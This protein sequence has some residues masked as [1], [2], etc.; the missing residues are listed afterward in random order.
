M[1][2]R[3]YNYHYVTNTKSRFAVIWNERLKIL[4]SFLIFC[5]YSWKINIF[6]S[7]N[8]NLRFSGL[9]FHEKQKKLPQWGNRWM[10][11]TKEVSGIISSDAFIIRN[12]YEW[13]SYILFCSHQQVEI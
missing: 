2:S 6:S 8:F 3:A 11:W 4:E 13:H 12:G 5:K 7:N 1:W 10:N 9:A